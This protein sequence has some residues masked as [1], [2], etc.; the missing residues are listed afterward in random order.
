MIRQKPTLASCLL[1]LATAAVAES[2]LPDWLR[3]PGGL[4]RLALETADVQD[5]EAAREDALQRAAEARLEEMFG[6]DPEALSDMSALELM[7]RLGQNAATDRAPDIEEP[8]PRQVVPRVRVETLRAPLPQGVFT[9]AATPLPTDPSGSTVLSI[10]GPKGSAILVV[11]DAVR[12]RILLRE[13]VA[14]PLHRELLLA[15]LSPRLDALVVEL[16]DKTSGRVIRRFRPVSRR[17]E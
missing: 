8:A 2:G 6:A 13:N 4:P 10:D 14:L 15:D 11:A 12:H 16:V 1:V 3:P 5:V 7:L 17:A 9:H